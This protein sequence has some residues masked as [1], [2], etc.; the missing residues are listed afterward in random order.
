MKKQK[1][2]INESNYAQSLEL[3]KKMDEL[4]LENGEL[5]QAVESYKNT[6]LNAKAISDFAHY[7]VKEVHAR[8]ERLQGFDEEPIILKNLA[9]GATILGGTILEIRGARVMQGI[10]YIIADK[11]ER[12]GQHKAVVKLLVDDFQVKDGK[13]F[14]LDYTDKIRAYEY[15]K[16]NGELFN[17]TKVKS[18]LSY[19]NW[20]FWEKMENE[21]IAKNL[22]ASERASK[23]K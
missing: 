16:Y 11:Y 12:H 6:I 5:R 20:D 18:L 3:I 2:T 22:K 17:G 8:A 4:G 14:I 21:R 10:T 13:L 9:S 1:Y 15:G 23:A 19:E 7:V